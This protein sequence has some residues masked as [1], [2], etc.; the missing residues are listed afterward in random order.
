M[1]P[2]FEI[3]SLGKNTIKSPINLGYDKGDGI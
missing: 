1:T 3:K 2:N